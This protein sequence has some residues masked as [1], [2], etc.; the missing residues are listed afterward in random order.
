MSKNIVLVVGHGS[1]VQRSNADFEN[2]IREFQKRIPERDVKI[3]YVE[4]AQPNFK[5]A[6]E[7]ASSESEKITVLPLFLLTAGHIKHDII[8]AVESARQKFPEV[9]FRVASALGVHDNMAQV[10]HK[11]LK[12]SAVMLPKKN[13][14]TSVL[15]IGR[16][17]SDPDANSDF[18][19]IVRL[20]EETMSYN[21]IAYCFIAVVRPKIEE[22][23]KRLIQEKPDA[24]LIQPY[25]IFPGLLFERLTALVKQYAQAHPDIS[26][27]LAST[28]GEDEFIFDVFEKRLLDA[29]VAQEKALCESCGGLLRG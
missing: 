4:L 20:V 8:N 3:S 5:N 26:F 15:M 27:Q 23:L 7:Q 17:S 25:L 14:K 12:E 13:L 2:F 21:R 22:V 9:K 19:K 1:R 16:G 28:L 18:C 6:L 10:V 29:K 11:R 24:V